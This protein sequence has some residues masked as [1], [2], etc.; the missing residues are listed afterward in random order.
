M[1]LLQVLQ[2]GELLGIFQGLIEIVRVDLGRSNL[3]GHALDSEFVDDLEVG[4][5]AE[6]GVLGLNFKENLVLAEFQVSRV[7]L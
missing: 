2:S 1:S 6:G 5:N 4:G 3:I 7:R